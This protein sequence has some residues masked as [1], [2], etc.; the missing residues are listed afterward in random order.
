MCKCGC[1]AKGALGSRER[2]RTSST[3]RNP[4]GEALRKGVGAAAAGAGGGEG[5]MAAGGAAAAAGAGEGVEGRPSKE[6]SNSVR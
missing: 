1:S 2:S 4:G 6:F 5:G 3:R